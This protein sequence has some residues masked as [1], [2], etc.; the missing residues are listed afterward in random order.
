MSNLLLNLSI[1]LDDVNLNYK[2]YFR[3]AY[4]FV[5]S[6]R[7]QIKFHTFLRIVSETNLTVQILIV[8][9]F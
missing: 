5:F 7:A 6:T 1:I 3:I 8:I 4:A 9:K 2:I